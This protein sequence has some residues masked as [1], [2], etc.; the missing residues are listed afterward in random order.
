M[1]EGLA[2]TVPTTLACMQG[3]PWC[4]AGAGLLRA[5]AERLESGCGQVVRRG[6]GAAMPGEKPFDTWL[7]VQEYSRHRLVADLGIPTQLAVKSPNSC[8]SDWPR[9][10]EAFRILQVYGDPLVSVSRSQHH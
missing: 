1:L 3:R 9:G 8:G 4:G 6:C 2:G 7:H 10:V 5:L